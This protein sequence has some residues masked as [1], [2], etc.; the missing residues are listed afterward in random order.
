M[1][2]SRSSMRSMAVTLRA[3]RAQP[4]AMWHYPLVINSPRE[5]GARTGLLP[6]R[7]R[8]AH[9]HQAPVL[10]ADVA[11]GGEVG[12]DAADHLARGAHAR[13]DVLV[14]ERLVDHQAAVA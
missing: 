11:A 7:R 12:E 4:N 13:G 8:L 9:D 3:R 10:L 14:R 1:R 2:R 5:F 6:A